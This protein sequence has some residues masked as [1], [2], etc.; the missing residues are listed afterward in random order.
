MLPPF[1]ASIWG[2][3]APPR[4]SKCCRSTSTAYRRRVDE[5]HVPMH[6]EPV[7][8][9][10]TPDRIRTFFE[11]REQHFQH[12]LR[13]NPYR[14]Y[15]LI[16]IPKKIFTGPPPGLRCGPR[17]GPRC[18]ARC[19]PPPGSMRAPMPGSMTTSTL[20]ILVSVKPRLALWQ[21]GGRGLSQLGAS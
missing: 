9:P 2:G 7:D 20:I 6:V 10:P 14:L 15:P 16:M 13:A 3:A 8:G 12:E 5:A 1:H 11:N 18:R 4:K 19:G 17:C 21:A